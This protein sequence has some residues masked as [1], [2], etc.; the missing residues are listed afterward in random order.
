M[1]LHPPTHVYQPVR[2]GAPPSASFRLSCVV[3][4]I[5]YPDRTK[6]TARPRRLRHARLCMSLMATCIEGKVQL[7]AGSWQKHQDNL[8]GF[9]Q[10]EAPP[11]KKSPHPSGPSACSHK[12]AAL[13]QCTSRGCLLVVV[14][15]VPRPHVTLKPN[16]AQRETG[17]RR[18][19]SMSAVTGCARGSRVV[20][21]RI[22]PSLLLLGLRST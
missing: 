21:R 14:G 16:A 7:G 1:H 17:G 8:S 18:W 20:R 9:A 2:Q 19:L 11:K 4:S 22:R 5:Q 12:P 15:R 10:L 13:F 3:S 6:N